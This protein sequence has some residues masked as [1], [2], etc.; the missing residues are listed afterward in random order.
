MAG[1]FYIV[2]GITIAVIAAL[3]IASD[4]MERKWREK[5]PPDDWDGMREDKEGKPWE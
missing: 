2:L 3:V 4:L 5:H 1:A